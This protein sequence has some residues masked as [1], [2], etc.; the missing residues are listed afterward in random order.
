MALDTISARN[1]RKR[2]AKRTA[3]PVMAEDIYAMQKVFEKN[4]WLTYPGYYHILISHAELMSKLS[5]EQ[6][7]MYL[8]L[9]Q[10][11]LWICEYANEIVEPLNKILEQFKSISTFYAI[12]CTPLKD[13]KWSKSSG[14]VLYEIKNP[15]VSK[16]LKKPIKILD[17][18]EDLKQLKIKD[19]DLFILVDDFVGTGDTADK[20]MA[21]MLKANAG[22]E[23]KMVVMSVAAHRE[24]INRLSAQG[25]PVFTSHV[26]K[27][28]IT[29]VYSGY[30]LSRYTQLMKDIEAAFNIKSYNFGYGGSEALIC[31]KRCPNNTFPIYWHGKK[32][33]YSRY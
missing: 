18:I 27:R 9:T 6:K 23:K 4:A 5:E 21:D 29:D 30:K 16:Q 25:I 1:R 14:I 15:S 22:V 11:L 26:L 2:Y 13:Q 7:N 31:L 3:K 20:C 10:E 33:P 17:R 12:R 32:S 8:D 28:G 19:S 24:G